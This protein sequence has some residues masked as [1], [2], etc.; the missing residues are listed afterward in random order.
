MSYERNI[1]WLN[2]RRVNYRQ[3]PI[4]DEPTFSNDHYSYYANGTYEYYNLFYTP[5]KITTYKSLKWHMLVLY[6]LNIDGVDGDDVSLEDDMRC[7]FKFIANKENGFVTFF[8][9][10]SV[11]DDMIQNVFN[12][13]G[14]APKNRARK[15]IFKDYNGL[16]FNEKMKVVGQLSGRQKLDKEKIY[17]T[18]LH[19]NDF[20]K[21]ITNGR[22]AGLL[23]CS[24][25]T[26]QRHMCADLKRE[27]Q[28]LNEEIQYS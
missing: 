5:S 20:G 15:I 13:G 26:I 23:D 28:R 21:P 18:M 10:S 6:Y 17:D 7:I 8:I 9:K 19:L 2:D 25:R 16:S 14:D 11:L 12:Q 24:I 4:N 27:K 1:K 22:L 3:E